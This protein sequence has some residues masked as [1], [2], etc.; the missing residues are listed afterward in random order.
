MEGRAR[1]DGD[2]FLN[3]GQLIATKAHGQRHGSSTTGPDI[4]KRLQG[5]AR[6]RSQSVDGLHHRAAVLQERHLVAVR[7]EPVVEKRLGC[8]VDPAPASPCRDRTIARARTHRAGLEA[9]VHDIGRRP[10]DD[11]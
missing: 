9:G 7:N 10:D 8:I 5:I 1:S 6:A 2:N 3:A 11:D 4:V